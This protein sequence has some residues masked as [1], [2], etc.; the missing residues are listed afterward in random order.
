VRNPLDGVPPVIPAF[1]VGIIGLTTPPG[2]V[3][4]ASGEADWPILVGAPNALIPSSRLS[5]AG[6]TGGT[7]MGGMGRAVAGGTATCC[8]AVVITLGG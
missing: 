3:M 6:V 4:G 1:A 7:G 2:G 5:E 8:A